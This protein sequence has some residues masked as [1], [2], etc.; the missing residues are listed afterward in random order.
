M[1]RV[2]KVGALRM[3]DVCRDEGRP[4]RLAVVDG[5]TIV[6]PWANMCEQDFNVIGVGLG[7]GMGQRLNYED[8]FNIDERLRATREFDIEDNG[9]YI[10]P[11]SVGIVEQIG[12]SG[13][14]TYLGL[15]FGDAEVLTFDLTAFEKVGDPS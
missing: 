11:G 5:A 15:R 7:T 10:T 1:S 13:K 14:R 2:V 9:L 8:V 4:P 12:W 6:G 3:C